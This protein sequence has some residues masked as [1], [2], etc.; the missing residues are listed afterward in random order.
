MN[1]F[2]GIPNAYLVFDEMIEV[3]KEYLSIREI[4]QTKRREIEA[5]ENITIQEIKVKREILIKYLE[6][7]F[8]ERSN[9]FKRLFDT[10]DSAILSH[11]NQALA[12]TLHSIVELA[13]SSPFKELVNLSNVRLALEDSDHIWEL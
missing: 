12:L 6:L 1:K 3:I 7:S 13:K 11:D 5:I 10:V 2:Q 9:S 8:D 4:E